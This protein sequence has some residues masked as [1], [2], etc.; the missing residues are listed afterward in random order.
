MTNSPSVIPGHI[1]HVVLVIDESSSMGLH[2]RDLIKVVDGEVAYLARRSQELDQET[3]VSVY[4]FG[5]QVRCLVYDKDV[6]RLPRIESLYRPAGRTRLIDATLQALDDL[7]QTATLYGDH[8]FLA[9]VL[10]DG[11]ENDSRE[12]PAMLA[13]RLDA[14]PDNWTVATLVPNQRGVREAKGFGFPASNIE[15]WDATNAGGVVEAGATMRRA[16]ESFLVG[17]ASGVRGTRSLFS[18]GSDAVNR[19]T[20]AGLTALTPGS[21]FIERPRVDKRMDE[22]VSRIGKGF[23]KLSKREEI[24][25]HK[26]IAIREKATGT[27]YLDRDARQVLGL[28]SMTV[29]VS[30]SYNPD[31]DIFVQSKA[32]NRKIPAGSEALVLR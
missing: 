24:Q 4:T 9:Y 10:T 32:P 25:D 15:V 7:A 5:S 22:I 17:R 18:T 3:R 16:T 13:R 29:K 28:P 27:V 21:F 20:V 1:N 8:A 19:S 26:L 2:A 23:Y 11:E 6:L 31:Y 30:P 14:L 12:R